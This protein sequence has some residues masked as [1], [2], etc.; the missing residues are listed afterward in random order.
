MK[1][2][3]KMNLRKNIHTIFFLNLILFILTFTGCA[4]FKV[5]P[6]KAP[7]KPMVEPVIEPSLITIPVNVSKSLKKNLVRFFSRNK[8]L[9]K[10]SKK[11]Q[12]FFDETPSLDPE[13]FNNVYVRLAIEKVWDALHMPI[14][15]NY[16]LA[17]LINPEALRVFPSMQKDSAKITIGLIAR[18]K[19]ISGDLS[20][21]EAQPV[22]RISV[23]S[24]EP[25]TG[26]HIVLE[27]ELSFDTISEE[28]T[29]KLSE[30]PYVIN[31]KKIAVKK[32]N[33]YGSGD[34]IVFAVNIAG[35][36]K[37][38][39]YLMGVPVFDES[40]MSVSISNIDY[41]IETNNIL[42]KT[43]DWVLHADLREK[44]QAQTHWV[45]SDKLDTIKDRL[46]EALNTKL[47]RYVSISGEIHKIQPITVGIT[48]TSLKA[49]LSAE[50]T[51]EIT[52]F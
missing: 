49:V 13:S 11:M 20:K 22:P 17:L 51:A 46:S 9:N 4:T 1:D 18:P 48:A 2:L 27:N 24:G 3:L 43:A 44:L 33:V 45:L 34:S 29:R 50:G 8:E 19:I 40:N 25:Q 30:K 28:L 10:F 15:L 26:F 38:T 47:N 36:A 31:G 12:R 14:R 35:A 39:V 32:V 6:P 37:G 5:P 41:T 7:V 42:V 23:Q 16:N 52:V 21:T